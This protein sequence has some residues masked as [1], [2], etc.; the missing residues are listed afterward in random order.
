MKKDILEFTRWLL[1]QQ[2]D[3][4]FHILGEN[5]FRYKYKSPYTLEQLYDLFSAKNG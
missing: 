2:K 5:S 3:K 4:G 1:E